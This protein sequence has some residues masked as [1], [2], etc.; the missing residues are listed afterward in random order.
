M[1]DTSIHQPKVWQSHMWKEFSNY[2]IYSYISKA[3]KV[4]YLVIF[5]SLCLVWNLGSFAL[6]EVSSFDS[7]FLFES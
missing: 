6:L 4:A 5:P 3:R 2:V 7:F 1:Q